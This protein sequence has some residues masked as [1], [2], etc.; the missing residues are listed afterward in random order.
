MP[1]EES[2]RVSRPE[3]SG[4]FAEAHTGVGLLPWSHVTE[5]LTSARNYWV[6]TSGP[7]G[8]PHSMP[9]WGL[10]LDAEL[11]FSTSPASR[12]SKNLVGNPLAVVH[13]ESGDEVVILEG[14]VREVTDAKEKQR[15]IE[16]YN[17]K[18]DW[19]MTLADLPDHSTFAVRPDK[20]FAWLGSQAESFTESATRWIFSE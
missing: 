4:Y 8:Q 17:P 7:G 12:K 11:V 14:R 5:A 13:L 20:A 9:V 3:P 16:R 2:P 18:Y 15:F 10:W 19:N 6:A 1:A